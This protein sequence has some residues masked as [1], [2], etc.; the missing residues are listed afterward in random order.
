[1]IGKYDL[2]FR[3]FVATQVRFVCLKEHRRICSLNEY[4]SVIC[5]LIGKY[6][7]GFRG[8]DFDFFFFFVSF[9]L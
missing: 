6:D 8:F 4:E 9:V 2:D 5:S 7:L 3:V 1:M